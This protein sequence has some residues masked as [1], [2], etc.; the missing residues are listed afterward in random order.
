MNQSGSVRDDG[1]KDQLTL[2]PL[3]TDVINTFVLNKVVLC[4]L[5]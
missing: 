3:E 1:D 4:L 2:I 5:L